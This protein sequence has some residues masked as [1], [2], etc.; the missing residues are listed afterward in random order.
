LNEPEIDPEAIEL[1]TISD[2]DYTRFSFNLNFLRPDFFGQEA[3]LFVEQLISDLNIYVVNPQSTT[4]EES[5][6][7][8]EEGELYRNWSEINARH[9]AH[10][11]EELELNYY[12][13]P[14]SNAVWKHNFNK[15]QVQDE[16]GEEYFVPKVMVLQTVADKRIVTLS[17]WPEGL[18]MLVPQVDYYLL[19]KKYKK[20]FKEVEESGLIS[21]K[22]F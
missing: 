12:P 22:A 6:T 9:S 4:D 3:F 19:V 10:F 13:L 16:L 5:A 1:E 7:R 11:Y 17:V 20:L 2:Y 15:R 21:A 14:A 8:P 18:P